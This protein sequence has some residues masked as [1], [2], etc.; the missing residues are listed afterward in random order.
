MAITP[1][2]IFLRGGWR[3]AGRVTAG[4]SDV[5]FRIGFY[6]GRRSRA[7]AGLYISAFDVT[8]GV[9]LI[10]IE[11]IWDELKNCMEQKY[12]DVHRSYK[13]LR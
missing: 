5:C 3:E 6:T 9:K 13:R 10:P 12:P 1:S 7:S 2:S 11:T 8:A 4:S